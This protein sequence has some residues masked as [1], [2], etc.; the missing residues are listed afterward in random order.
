MSPGR[1]RIRN[2]SDQGL[3]IR[4]SLG[5]RRSLLS[6]EGERH[7]GIHLSLMSRGSIDV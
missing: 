3:A 6:D 5:A 4:W 7:F 2:L 1:R